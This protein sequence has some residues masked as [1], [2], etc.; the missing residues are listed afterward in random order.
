MTKTHHIHSADHGST[1]RRENCDSSCAE[2]Q[3]SV[4]HM[5]TKRRVKP[6][7]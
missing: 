1:D 6:S 2:P 3:N 7:S 5:D 4:L